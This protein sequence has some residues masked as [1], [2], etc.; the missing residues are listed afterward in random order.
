M[1]QFWSPL[2]GVLAIAAGLSYWYG[3]LKESLAVLA[4]I[5]LNALIG[6]A[7]EWSAR[8]TMKALR[9]L[10]SHRAAV[11]RNGLLVDI[12]AEELVPGDLIN[13]EAGMLV[14]ADARLIR[15]ANLSVNESVLTGESSSVSKVTDQL[16]GQL[17]VGDRRNI[18]YQ[19]TIVS[20]GNALALVTATGDE[21]EL[22]HL[23][24]ITSVT[25]SGKSPLDQKLASLSLRLI[26]LTLGIAGVVLLL[27]LYKG[28]DIYTV[29][30]TA[31]ALAVAA[32]PEGLPVVATLTLAIGMVR[33]ARHRVVV[34]TLSAV[35]TLG[36]TQILMIDK[37]GTL[38]ENRLEVSGVSLNQ[39]DRSGNSIP[40]YSP[41]TKA[42]LLTS[43]AHEELLKVAIL[44][45]NAEV[46]DV[47]KSGPNASVGDPLEIALLRY[48]IGEGKAPKVV[49]ANW[50]R[51]R[52]N[53][54]SSESGMMATL[55]RESKDERSGLVCVK[56]AP[57]VV[58]ASCNR[59]LS[60][61]G[62]QVELNIEQFRAEAETLAGQGLKVLAF[63]CRTAEDQEEDLARGL[64]LLGLVSFWDPPRAG[65]RQAIDDCQT[66]GIRVVMAT[67]D[68]P[69]TARNIGLRTGLIDDVG[70]LVVTGKEL[71]R[72]QVH[73]TDNEAPKANIYARV[74]PE[75]KL[76]LL[77]RFQ[78]A[79][80]V[81]GMAGDGVNDAPA[82]RR[83]DIGIAM[84][85]GGT[86]A[87]K[88]AADLILQ[89]NSFTAIV[90]AIRHGRGIFDNIRL[91]VVY[92]LSC[93]LSELLI[94][95]ASFMVD[96]ATPLLPLQILFLNMVTDVFPAL[97]L[98]FTE[99][100]EDVLRRP[101]R[102]REEGFLD[103]AAWRAI[104][105][106]AAVICIVVLSGAYFAQYLLAYSTR[107]SRNLI[108]FTL[109]SS[110]LWHIFSL[111]KARSSVFN[112]VIT[113]NKYVWLAILIC[114]GLT[115]LVYALPSARDMLGLTAI[116]GWVTIAVPFFLGLI[117]VL[118]IRLLKA[119]G[120][121][122]RSRISG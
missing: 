71:A 69:A 24:H 107:E 28:N 31:I 10:S 106:Y 86:D 21:T 39:S 55:H 29:I 122:D 3:E 92:L 5:M 76:S 95:G 66:A 75:Q 35:E 114:L 36:Q 32:I 25:G 37:T 6:F 7:M 64:T 99:T 72:P 33:L 59:A 26:W 41:K 111:P 98:G 49:R 93:N 82:I 4:V 38:T 113:N 94:I 54:F 91:F 81:V 78:Q 19:G 46:V 80:F 48:A 20:R 65:I 89:D 115:W 90:E 15:Q 109:L 104:G 108:F 67:G 40:S 79:G 96:F 87:A 53:P 27:G 11:Y 56:G 57:G 74:T 14:P 73:R 116:R 12:N 61:D 58:F 63:A 2:V 30:K 16:S 101:P 13:L 70:A 50:P 88:E 110:Q 47:R 51:I 121:L 18:I 62:E 83:A 34:K 119:T 22:G 8:R 120:L 84:G 60:A 23:V 112:N 117:P 97:A 17:V 44:C 100:G 103:L 45:N 9:D 1:G 77:A 102:T 68:H 42:P 118:V 43:P 85:E 52:E 105:I